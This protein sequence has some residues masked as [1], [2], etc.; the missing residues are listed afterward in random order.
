[1]A[2]S[3]FVVDKFGGL[4]VFNDPQELGPSTAIDLLNADLDQRGRV[5]ARD[6]SS[7]L[8]AAAASAP[9]QAL[10]ATTASGAEQA[11]TN[12]NGTLT[13]YALSGGAAGTTQAVLASVTNNSFV[14]FGTPAAT[15][16]YVAAG[17]LYRYDGAWTAIGAAP[18][19]PGIIA[20]TANDNRLVISDND[21][22]S[23]SDAG[24]PETF[25]A[26]NFVRLWPGDG[27]TVTALIRWRDYLF[28][29]KQTK[30][31]VFTGTSTDSAG[32]PIFNYR[33][34]DAG[35]GAF[36]RGMA[37]A[38]E[39]GVYFADSTGIY[40]TSGDKP[41]YISRQI[42]PWLRSGS[43]GSLPAFSLASSLTLTYHD[44]RLYVTYP[45]NA[46]SVTLVYDPQIAAW[47]VWQLGAVSLGTA[48][49]TYTNRGL[50]FGDFTSKKVAKMDS[51]VA[52]DLGSA[53]SWSWTSAPYDL[54]YPGQVKI[55]RESRLWGVG[56]VTLKVANDYSSFDTGSALTLGTNPTVAD[57]WQQIDREGTLWQHKL[58]GTG[59]ASVSRLEH[60]ISFVKPVG[61]G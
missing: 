29:F 52:T 4:D 35:R 25:G 46:S 50:Y 30:F 5:R 60:M 21:K 40:L 47:S 19:T 7:A 22:I 32:N 33:S 26:N 6:G 53:F 24:A 12:I 17:V 38:G 9:T 57:A 2:T 16:A 3:P 28:A 27:E 51:S 20:V 23:F 59:A 42:E 44:R 55:T 11:I 10:F 8:T 54:G 36:A 13:P 41:V 1:V 49:Q 61:V 18:I 34:V 39:E 14:N 45:N 48:P 31:A 43:F 15:R 56:T 37:V 58:S